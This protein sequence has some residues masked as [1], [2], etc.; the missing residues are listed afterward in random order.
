MSSDTLNKAPDGPHNL[1]WNL[2]EADLSLKRFTIKASLVEDR[3]PIAS[4]QTQAYPTNTD[5]K[6]FIQITRGIHL[7]LARA[8]FAAR[9]FDETLTVGYLEGNNMGYHDDGK[10]TLGPTII[11]FSLD[12][13][14]NFQLRPQN[15]PLLWLHWQKERNTTQICL[16][17]LSAINARPSTTWPKP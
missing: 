2:Q 17:T 4:A 13:D 8:N 3:W 10:S 7:T 9:P 1:L 12:S 16:W 14:C 5:P 6:A 11:A 15:E